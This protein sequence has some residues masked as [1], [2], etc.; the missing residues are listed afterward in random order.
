MQVKCLKKI[1]TVSY[2]R[3]PVVS[4]T[5]VKVA[6]LTNRSQK[7]TLYGCILKKYLDRRYAYYTCKVDKEKFETKRKKE[8]IFVNILSRKLLTL[9]EDQRD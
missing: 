4:Y 9:S 2:E 8:F 6:A 1:R 7:S 5:T 3:F